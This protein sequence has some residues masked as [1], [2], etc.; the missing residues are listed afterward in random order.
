VFKVQSIRSEA[1]TCERD[2]FFN[3]IKKIKTPAR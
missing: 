3:E 1:W 2:I